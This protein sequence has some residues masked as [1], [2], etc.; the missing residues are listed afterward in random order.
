ME[1]SCDLRGT[2][3][4]VAPN[5]FPDPEQDIDP[6]GAPGEQTAVL[7]G[8]C[9]WCVEAVFKE[10]EGVLAVTSGYAGGTAQT[11]DY[12]SVCSGATDHAEVV[13]VRF[14]PARITFGQLLKVFFSVAHDPTQLDRQ[15]N[16]RGPQ[17]RSAIF[18]ADPAQ[19]E[20]AEAYIHQL[21]RAGVFKA[22]IVTRLEPLEAFYPAEE[23]HQDY[24]ARNPAQP[25][26]AFTAAPKVEKLRSQFGDRLKAR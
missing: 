19:K 1:G 9:F 21:E 5:Q 23:S 12:R 4:A 24:A 13:Q 10:L 18:Y 26:I 17:Y 2:A 22:P 6:A 11:A 15:G 7:A 8:G 20:V 25:Y 14:D 3:L 16:D